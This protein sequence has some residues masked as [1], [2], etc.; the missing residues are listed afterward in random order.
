MSDKLGSTKKGN[1]AAATPDESWLPMGYFSRVH[2]L[3][4]GLFLKTPDRRRE[5]GDYPRVLVVNDGAMQEYKIE[6]S[7]VSANEPVLQLEGVESREAAQDLLRAQVFVN[8][9]DL[10]E[11]ENEDDFLVADL[12]GLKVIAKDRGEIGEVVGV[13]DFGAQENL[14]IHLTA[15]NTVVYYPFLEEYILDISL[16]DETITVVYLPEF[17][18][19][20]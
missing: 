16:D 6:R 2:G 1:A 3:K 20:S 7:Y 18:E 13:V 10:D 11:D 12:L 8:R 9:E 4:G 15:S 17:L 19:E 5:L 14:E